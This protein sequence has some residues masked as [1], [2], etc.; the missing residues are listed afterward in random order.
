M[1]QFRRARTLK[2]T[3]I[4]SRCSDGSMV[5][6][7]VTT[8][9]SHHFPVRASPT[10]V[11]L[12][13][14]SKLKRALAENDP[15][16]LWH[17]KSQTGDMTSLVF[18]IGCQESN[19]SL[20]GSDTFTESKTCKSFHDARYANCKQSTSLQVSVKWSELCPRTYWATCSPMRIPAFRGRL[21][22]RLGDVHSLP[23]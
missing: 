2:Q 3:R 22:K 20:D 7:P 6:L 15:T 10:V 21:R 14:Q 13:Q 17:L 9:F 4:P 19:S 1:S 8:G 16:V 11:T 12:W 23:D 5:K 18:F